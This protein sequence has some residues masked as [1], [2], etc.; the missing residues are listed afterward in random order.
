MQAESKGL[1][2]ENDRAIRQRILQ[3]AAE[4]PWTNPSYVNVVVV[5][6]VAHLWGMVETDEQRQ[7]WRVLAENV[8]G[9]HRVEDHLQKP[10]GW[11]FGI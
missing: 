10:P 4:Q 7:G 2:T 5:D 6:G 8:S 3:S 11:A 9:V 1:P